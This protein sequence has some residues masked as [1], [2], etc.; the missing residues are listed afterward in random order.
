[1]SEDNRA[2]A[3]R[4]EFQNQNRQAS[5]AIIYDSFADQGGMSGSSVSTKD[6]S[7]FER[8]Y[9]CHEIAFE[10]SAAQREVNPDFFE[11]HVKTIMNQPIFEKSDNFIIVEKQGQHDVQKNQNTQP[12]IK[13]K[14]KFAKRIVYR[15]KKPKDEEAA[16]K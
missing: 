11:P 7:D 1:M 4:R 2:R 9:E 3:V 14:K 10:V 16:K 5:N 8:S 6:N 15:A 12:P 13:K